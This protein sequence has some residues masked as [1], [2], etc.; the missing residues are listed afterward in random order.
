VAQAKQRRLQV[1][2]LEVR[3]VK[4]APTP[5]EVARELNLS[6]AALPYVLEARWSP[7]VVEEDGDRY[8][9]GIVS[10]LP[11]EE[12]PEDDPELK[13]FFDCFTLPGI[14]GPEGRMPTTVA[15]EAE[16]MVEEFDRLD[17]QRR[18]RAALK[19]HE[20]LQ[21]EFFQE[22]PDLLD[23]F[24]MEPPLSPIEVELSLVL[25]ALW[26]DLDRASYLKTSARDA[27]GPTFDFDQGYA[28]GLRW[29]GTV[30]LN[31]ITRRRLGFVAS[32]GAPWRY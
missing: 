26:E 13:S 22:N 4:G 8:L 32:G 29:A 27:E 19:R 7:D 16:F 11:M 10:L 17:Q 31:E 23:R 18:L 28:A 6:L 14:G 25:N 21:R 20:E 30:I 15:L 3:L 5:E 24:V 12:L 2:E 9:R 1:L